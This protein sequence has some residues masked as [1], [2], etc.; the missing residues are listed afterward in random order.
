[1]WFLLNEIDGNIFFDLILKSIYNARHPLWQNANIQIFEQS[2]KSD[3]KW[4][5][6]YILV[7]FF[8]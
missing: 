5:F 1:M 2:R 3:L 7:H 6:S 8:M 4:A